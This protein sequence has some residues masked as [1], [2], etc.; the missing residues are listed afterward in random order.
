MRAV[1]MKYLNKATDKPEV[2]AL[3]STDNHTH[4][5]AQLLEHA[6]KI[7]RGKIERGELEEKHIYEVNLRN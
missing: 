4:S 5:T 1:F 7:L 3:A 2:V 6:A